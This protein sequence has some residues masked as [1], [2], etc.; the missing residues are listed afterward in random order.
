MDL[1]QIWQ[2]VSVPDN[3][4]IVLLAILVP[5]YTWYAVR[6]AMANDRLIASLEA[7]PAMAKT[8]HR[9][10]F[11]FRPGWPKEVQVWPYL[12]RIEFLA[13]LVITLLLMVWSI[14]L[15]APLEEPANPNF[16]MNPAK[17]PWY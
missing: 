4:P 17:A 12:L 3:I 13:A 5:F 11:P 7:N 10:T 16:T 9:K 1:S 15:N 8:H 6:Q 2:I 14:T